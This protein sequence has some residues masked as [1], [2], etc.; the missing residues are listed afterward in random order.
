LVSYG[1]SGEAIDLLKANFATLISVWLD[2]LRVKFK[3]RM[4]P[5]LCEEAGTDFAPEKAKKS[6]SQDNQRPMLNKPWVV[7]SVLS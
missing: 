4:H 7:L 1:W 6:E 2:T 3:P 5:K